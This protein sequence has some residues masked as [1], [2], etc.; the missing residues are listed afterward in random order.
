M[1]CTKDAQKVYFSLLQQIP[2][3]RIVVVKSLFVSKKK[4][5]FKPRSNYARK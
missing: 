1:C 4:P 3:D 5:N 2:E